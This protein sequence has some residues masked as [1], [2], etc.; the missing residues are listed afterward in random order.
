MR[1]IRWGTLTLAG[2]LMISLGCA[3]TT[4]T[5]PAQRRMALLQVDPA[6]AEAQTQLLAGL[7]D[8]DPLV[9]RTAARR[10]AMTPTTSVESLTLLIDNEDILVRRTGLSALLG[11]GGDGALVASARALADSNVMVRLAAV[12][13][14]AA[15][16][17]FSDRVLDL[18]ARASEDGDDKIRVIATRATWPFYRSAT[19]IRDQ[20]T[21]DVDVRVTQTI[22]LPAAGWKFQLDPQRH[23]HR[24]EWFAPGLDDNGWDDMAIEQV[25][26]DAGY[27]YIGVGW[28]RRT[29]QLPDEPDLRG[30]DLAFGAVDESAW[31]WVNGVYAGDHDT[32]PAGWNESFRLDVTGLLKW[33]E[34]NQITVR[35]M[36]TAHAGGVYKPVVI[37]VLR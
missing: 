20:Q 34:T 9:R 15:A 31:V 25:W 3:G 18:L 13:Y 36:N 29:I 14:L 21:T 33:G 12:E 23:G 1:R 37:E 5:T 11:R 4:P 16:R 35:A 10:L 2:I 17:P 26:Q 28:Y 24:L 6:T 7:S 27:D 30:A 19:S 8:E 22:P 32:G